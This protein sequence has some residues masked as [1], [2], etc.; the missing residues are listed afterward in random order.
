MA[1]IEVN[2]NKTK[3]KQTFPVKVPV[4]VGGKEK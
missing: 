1:R 3:W 2:P 4:P